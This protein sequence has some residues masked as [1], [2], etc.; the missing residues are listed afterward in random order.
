MRD[1]ETVLAIIGERGKRGQPLERVYRLVYNPDLYL[2][3]YARLYRNKRAMTP[4]STP[5]TVD[6]MALAKI[7]RLID[8]VRHERQRWTPV[9]RTYIPKKTGNK[10]RPLGIPC[11]SD[12]LL[13][14]VIR[15]IL[16]AYYEPQFSNVSHGLRPNRGCHSALQHI[17]QH[18]T[19]TRWWIEGDICRCFDTISHDVLLS[20]LAE[21]IHDQRFLRLIGDLLQAG[22]LEHWRYH[23]TPSGTPQGGGASPILANI[24]LNKLDQYVETEL[25][26]AYTRATK[27]AINPLYAALDSKLQRRKKQPRWAEVKALR[28]QKRRLPSQD[29]HDPT[30][31]RLRYIGYADDILFG[32]AGPRHEAEEIKRHLG[33]FLGCQLQLEL[34]N[35][36]TLI[37]QAS[38]QGARFLGYEIV[39]QY[40]DEQLDRHGRRSINGSIGLRVP[41]SVVERHRQRYLA[42]AKPIHRATLIH[43][44]DYSI[45]V[46][47]QQEY[48]G[49]VQYYAL[50][51][52]VCWFQRLHQ[53]ARASLLKTLAA[54]HKARTSVMTG[55]YRATVQTPDGTTLRCLQVRIPREGKPPLIAQFGG[56]P[57]RRQAWAILDERLPEVHGFR[58]TELLQRL[59]AEECELC[60]SHEQIDVD[61][62]RKLADLQRRGRAEP[63]LWVKLMAARRRKSLVVCRDCHT[64]IHTGKPTRQQH[65]E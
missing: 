9:R 59:L 46:R 15:S 57:L 7:E 39:T 58:R 55:K 42:K 25:I 63:S 21:Q 14:E 1:A 8:D 13:Q 32:F 11:W 20:I 41:A 24:L 34:S 3:A 60:G 18:W 64:K 19:G 40:C 52:N 17:Q 53:V 44:T 65:T 48:R 30:Y 23:Q 49:I 27:R 5:E 33:D 36:K 37:T 6:G 28:Q 2:R 26:P 10:L 4:G 47:Y 16:E 54:K 12:K 45:V 51:Q 29:P 35:E 50:A 43:D 31:R 22:Y 61:H 62:I 56:I 38:R